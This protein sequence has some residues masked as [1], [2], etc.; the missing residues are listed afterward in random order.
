[1][2]REEARRIAPAVTAVTPKVESSPTKKLP[3]PVWTVGTTNFEPAPVMVV[4]PE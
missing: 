4:G 2:V 1:M 3:P